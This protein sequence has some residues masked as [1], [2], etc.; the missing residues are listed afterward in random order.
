MKIQIHL[1]GSEED[2]KKSAKFLEG[3]LLQLIHT[4]IHEDVDKRVIEPSIRGGENYYLEGY[5][6]TDFDKTG[7]KVDRAYVSV[8]DLVRGYYEGFP[9]T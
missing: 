5:Y 2:L 3:T 6:I 4:P 7:K 8:R 1:E 9:I